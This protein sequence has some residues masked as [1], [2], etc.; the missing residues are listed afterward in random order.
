MKILVLADGASSHTERYVRQLRVQGCEVVAASLEPGSV[1]DVALTRSALGDFASYALLAPELREL[2]VSEKPDI[3][4][5]HFATAYGFAAARC[6][7]RF[8]DLNAAWALTVWGSDILV[9]PNKSLFHRWRVRYALSQAQIIVADS[10]YLEEQTKLYTKGAVS[11]IPWGIER[12]YVGSDEALK[13]KSNAW[14]DSVI[15]VMAPRPH[16]R[17]YRNDLLLE[18]LAPLL[19]SSRI[20]LTVSASGSMLGPFRK[21]ANELE[22]NNNIAYYDTLARDE[23]IGLLKEHHVYASASS[24][25]SSPVS[26]IEALALGV[27][28]LMADHPGLNDFLD[29]PLKAPGLFDSAKPETVVEKLE[30]LMAQSSAERLK[31][32]IHNRNRVR[33]MGVHEDNI[34]QTINLY[35]WLM[36]ENKHS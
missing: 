18:G 31:M 24:S 36:C 3:I 23:Y 2:I 11:V 1:I 28:P 33:E 14:S 25:D 12:E 4:N 16:E 20:A 10:T 22:V 29:G 32:F 19:R 21:R 26:M 15:R 34:I 13:E 7:R 5:S 27:A 8:G 9:S 30:A 17:L 6:R 35:Q